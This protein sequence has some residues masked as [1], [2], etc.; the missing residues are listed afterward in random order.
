MQPMLWEND[1][2][3]PTPHVK[4]LEDY[5]FTEDIAGT[6]IGQTCLYK[7]VAKGF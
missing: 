2:Q 3:I 1:V 6:H 7:E 5:H 4:N